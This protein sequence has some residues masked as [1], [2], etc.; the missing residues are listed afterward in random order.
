MIFG[1]GY[2][3]I[4]SSDDAGATFNELELT[5]SNV[6]P[7]Y[8][9]RKEIEHISPINGYRNFVREWIH[10]EFEITVHLH[11]HTNPKAAFD[12]F[13]EL[14]NHDCYLKIH[15]YDQDGMANDFIKNEDEENLIFHCTKFLPTDGINDRLIIRLK[16]TKKTKFTYLFFTEY[17][18]FDVFNEWED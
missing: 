7:N 16:S 3:V 8:E 14:L 12:A 13:A 5:Y 2:P 6:K 4:T 1:R 18:W 9:E 17:S 15:R 11:L 10:M